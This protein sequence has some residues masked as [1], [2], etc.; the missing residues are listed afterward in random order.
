VIFFRRRES[1]TDDDVNKLT[2]A[3]FRTPL[4]YEEKG[5]FLN[6]F[7]ACLGK[8]CTGAARV[9]LSSGPFKTVFD[10]LPQPEKDIVGP[11]IDKI[12]R[13]S[14]KEEDVISALQKN[15]SLTPD[16]VKSFTADMIKFAYSSDPVVWEKITNF[17]QLN[18]SKF[19]D[20]KTDKAKSDAVNA[21]I[22]PL[23]FP[24]LKRMDDKANSV[25]KQ[26]TGVVMDE[27]RQMG[28]V[29]GKRLMDEA[30]QMGDVQG[31]RLMDEKSNMNLQGV[32]N[33]Q[34]GVDQGKR[35]SGPEPD[36]RS[37][38]FNCK[39]GRGK[40]SCVQKSEI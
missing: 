10:K 2:A 28:D 12:L 15:T 8:G 24:A 6:E 18:K 29:Q 17:S 16:E 38:V 21:V 20:A 40:F 26:Q 9:T 23:I 30:R 3:I 39:V 14:V 37:G 27:A 19:P 36:E 4:S 25:R 32:R 22:G 33:Q 11:M 13:E 35:E 1:Y 31:K 34:M 5:I 7:K